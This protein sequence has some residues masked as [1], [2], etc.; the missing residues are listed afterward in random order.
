MKVNNPLTV[1]KLIKIRSKADWDKWS[2]IL[3]DLKY[4]YIHGG[5]IPSYT[6]G[7]SFPFYFNCDEDM[8]VMYCKNIIK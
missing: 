1:P 5:K 6:Q 3:N 7:F 8:T 2:K 4:Q